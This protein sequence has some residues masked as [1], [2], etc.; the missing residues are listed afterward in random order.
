MIT[1]EEH[2]PQSEG[3]QAFGGWGEDTTRQVKS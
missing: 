3:R 1:E 2:R